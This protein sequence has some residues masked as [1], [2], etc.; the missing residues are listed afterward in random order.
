MFRAY[1]PTGLTQLNPTDFNIKLPEPIHHP[2]TM[3]TK[4]KPQTK[5]KIQ[6]EHLATFERLP[7]KK[8]DLMKLKDQD[9]KTT[10]A[11]NIEVAKKIEQKTNTEP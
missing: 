4:S 11:D 9:E 5:E 7:D 3:S 10:G 8:K 2:L 6:D 1:H